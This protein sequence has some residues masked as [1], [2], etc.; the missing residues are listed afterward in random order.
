MKLLLLS[1]DVL[2]KKTRLASISFG[3]V[4]SPEISAVR[5]SKIVQPLVT[6]RLYTAASRLLSTPPPLRLSSQKFTR[7]ST[8]RRYLV[9]ALLP[10]VVLTETLI[11]LAAP[12]LLA[13]MI[14]LRVIALTQAWLP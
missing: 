1:H 9:I 11:E 7:R 4:R 2:Y 14:S 13:A 10:R 12:G 6:D 8:C 3:R 5:C